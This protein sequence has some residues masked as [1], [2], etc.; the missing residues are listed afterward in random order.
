VLQCCAGSGSGD[1]VVRQWL[2]DWVRERSF[3]TNAPAPALPLP[4]CLADVGDAATAHKLCS[5]CVRACVRF[6]F[7]FRFR[8]GFGFRFGECCWHGWRCWG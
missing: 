2:E 6:R 8:F 4:A 1:V 7:C 5:A 3:A